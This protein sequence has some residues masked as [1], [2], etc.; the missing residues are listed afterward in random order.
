M[1]IGVSGG[2]MLSGGDDSTSIRETSAVYTR[3]AG[4]S[5]IE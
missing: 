5:V 2:V 3:L 1:I 4:G